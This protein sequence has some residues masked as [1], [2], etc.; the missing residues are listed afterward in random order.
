[1]KLPASLTA[2]A[3]AGAA[4][5]LAGPAAADT[6]KV[7][8]PAAIAPADRVSPDDDPGVDAGHFPST[9]NVGNA[10]AV[11]G[12]S[13]TLHDVSS[14]FPA[15]LDVLLVAPDGH[16]VMLMS[17]AAVGS[18]VSHAD[19]TFSD[20]GAPLTGSGGIPSGSYRP[21]NVGSDHGDPDDA[22][23]ER[24]Q[25]LTPSGTTLD[26]LDG[27]TARGTWKLYV[28]DDQAGDTNT[29][30]G[31]WSMAL[32]ITAA[33]TSVDNGGEIVVPDRPQ[34]G[35]PSEVLKT[36][37]VSGADGVIDHLSV[38]LE[39]FEFTDPDDI[40]VLLVG[41]DGQRVVLVSDAAPASFGPGANLAF[42]DTARFH[43]SDSFPR[44]VD[45]LLPTNF[46]GGSPDEADGDVFPAPAPAP[47]YSTS[48]DAFRGTSPNG[49]WKLF[50]TDDEHNG[51]SGSFDGG[52][53]I[54]FNLKPAPAPTSGG[55]EPPPVGKPAPA[56]TPKATP[57]ALTGL[58][59]KPRTF[60][61]KKGTSIRY[62]L[63]GKAKVRF[64][65][66]RKAGKRFKKVPGKLVQ[67][68]AAGSN[69]LRFKRRL[70]PGSYRLTATP[71]GGK[72]RSTSFR[73]K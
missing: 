69:K 51:S 11:S 65:V 50:V 7:A 62:K 29:I 72:P 73:V 14:T 6:Q 57:P 59:L 70:A 63:S 64:T 25:D 41:P 35:P 5:A 53:G 12:V 15:D 3:T 47:P 71:A 27:T 39:G 32:S 66:A 48:L 42:T 13:V 9:I 10:G 23:P 20:G 52:W 49:Q 1:M 34:V 16:A 46:I 19:L 44:F 45:A 67:S 68:G 21:T 36:N 4:L 31:G 38:N 58:K 28:V 8:N 61:A 37:D 60:T 54:D 18:S 30:A 2:L 55:A 26:S 24:G 33:S 56:P 40:D 22:F 43:A 17:D